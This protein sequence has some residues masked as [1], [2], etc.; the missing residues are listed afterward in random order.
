MRNKAPL[1]SCYARV[2]VAAALTVYSVRTLGAVMTS[3]RRSIA[4]QVSCREKYVCRVE[5]YLQEIWN[6][7]DNIM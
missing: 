5:A 3:L 7:K 2:K 6:F 1:L 4:T